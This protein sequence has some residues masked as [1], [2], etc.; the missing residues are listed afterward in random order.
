MAVR[1]TKDLI[2]DE[3]GA[4]IEVRRYRITRVED[5]KKLSPDLCAEHAEVIEGLFRKL[6]GGKRGQS[7]AR[8]VL[9]EEQ[10]A[11]RRRK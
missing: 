2:C 9:T 10:I 8:V 5:G 4:D 1:V 7:R 6:P 3:C 11:A